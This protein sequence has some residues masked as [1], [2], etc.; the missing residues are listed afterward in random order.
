MSREISRFSSV[1]AVSLFSSKVDLDV[2]GERDMP[3][4]G[5]RFHLGPEPG[6]AL[7]R[8]STIIVIDGRIYFGLI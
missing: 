8:N 2:T 7:M 3:F 6:A 5:K 1:G 4:Q